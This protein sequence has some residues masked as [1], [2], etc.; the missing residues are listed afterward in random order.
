MA[1]LKLSPIVAARTKGADLKP[2][3]AITVEMKSRG[4]L[5]NLI[6]FPGQ[7]GDNENKVV[8]PIY[9]EN[10]RHR[11]FALLDLQDDTTSEQHL[12]FA[13]FTGGSHQVEPIWNH[14]SQRLM[15]CVQNSCVLAGVCIIAILMAT[16]EGKP[17]MKK[18]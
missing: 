15:P 8:I 7:K 3:F 1:V 2:P 14:V 4:V 9:P 18:D 16:S 11:S 17:E 10:L 12:L 13:L 5:R 6:S